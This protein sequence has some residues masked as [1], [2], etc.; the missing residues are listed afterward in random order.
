[1][2]MRWLPNEVSTGPWMTP[3]CSLNATWRWEKAARTRTK[4][5]RK[6]RRARLHVII[7]DLCEIQVIECICA[8]GKRADADG[9][10]YLIELRHHLTW[11]E[12]TKS[13]AF[14]PTG[15]GAALLGLL[16][17]LRHPIRKKSKSCVQWHLSERGDPLY[18]HQQ[19]ASKSLSELAAE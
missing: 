14:V 1:M 13:A 3:T 2:R 6:S 10:T 17:K 15:T 7:R 5:G 12:W 16:S 9:F 4:G 18:N 8:Q 19:Y 11:A